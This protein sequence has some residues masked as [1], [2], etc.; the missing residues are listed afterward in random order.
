MTIA[1]RGC[2]IMQMQHELSQRHQQSTALDIPHLISARLQ[3]AVQLRAS[4]GLGTNPVHVS[5]DS[6]TQNLTYSP[7]QA[8]DHSSDE[9]PS[10]N[11]LQHT[12]GSSVGH[13]RHTDVFRVVNSEGDRLSGLVVDR[14]GEQLVVSS[15]AAWVERYC[16]SFVAHMQCHVL[17]KAC[18][19]AV[20]WQTSSDACGTG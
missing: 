3:T 17:K 18:L 1:V 16:T 6:T 4:L 8:T 9:A 2:R 19:T 10:S 14:V 13:E 20:L 12:E 15:S 7:D 11:S 5:Q